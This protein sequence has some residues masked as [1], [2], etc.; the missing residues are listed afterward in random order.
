MTDHYIVACKISNFEASR[1]HITAPLYRDKRQFNNEAYNEDLFSKLE[2]LIYFH[3]PLNC[4]NFDSVFD[5]FVEIIA[6]TINEHAPQKRLSRKQAKLALKPWITKGTLTS[7]RKKNSLFKTHF[8][9][10]STSQ[11]LFFRKYSNKLTKIKALSKQMR[12][13]TELAK[14]KKMHKRPRI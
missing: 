1:K 12:F 11:K 8:I 10:G 9:N 2:R 14:N 5:Q 7:I 6:E 13:H 4:K 3:F